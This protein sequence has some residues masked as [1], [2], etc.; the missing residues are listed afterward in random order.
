MCPHI[1]TLLSK[2]NSSK[3]EIRRRIVAR[4]QISLVLAAKQYGLCE[5]TMFTGMLLLLLLL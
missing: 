4:L 5:T 2:W 3:Q 1:Y